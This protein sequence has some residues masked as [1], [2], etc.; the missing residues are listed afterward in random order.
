MITS[1]RVDAILKRYD[2]LDT[3]ARYFAEERRQGGRSGEVRVSSS[4]VDE[5]VNTA[6]HCH[7]EYEWVERGSLEEF[8]AWIDKRNASFA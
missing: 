2:D 1:K 7:P 3:L 5:H 4:G 8:K 6:C